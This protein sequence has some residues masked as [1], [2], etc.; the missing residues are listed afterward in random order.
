MNKK[1]VPYKYIGKKK[2]AELAP[3]LQKQIRSTENQ[4][5]KLSNKL[6]KLYDRTC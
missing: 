3:K 1:L 2:W 5:F 4:Y 6:K